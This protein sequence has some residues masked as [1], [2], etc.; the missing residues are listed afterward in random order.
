VDAQWADN[1]PGLVAVLLESADAVL[2]LEPVQ[3][4]A[5]RV[6][7]GVVGPYPEGSETAFE[8]RAFF[9]DQHGTLLEDPVTGSLNAAVAQWLFDSGRVTGAYMASQGARRG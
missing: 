4:H 9:T 6:D 1:G 2:R 7:I 5:T 8:L 3:R